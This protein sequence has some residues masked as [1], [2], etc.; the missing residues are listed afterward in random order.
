MGVNFPATCSLQNHEISYVR[1][2]FFCCFL[3]KGTNDFAARDHAIKNVRTRGYILMSSNTIGPTSW[4]QRR[5]IERLECCAPVPHTWTLRR[6][7]RNCCTK[8][9]FL[10]ITASIQWETRQTL[11]QVTHV[12][13]PTAWPVCLIGFTGA[14]V[15][16]NADPPSQQFP[17]NSSHM[18]FVELALKGVLCTCLGSKGALNTRAL[19]RM[20]IFLW[21]PRPGWYGYAHAL[22]TGQVVGWYTAHVCNLLLRLSQWES[23]L[24]KK[25]YFQLE[26]AHLV[27]KVL[28]WSVVHFLQVV[29]MGDNINKANK[30]KSKVIDP[31]FLAQIVLKDALK[32]ICNS[33]M[34]WLLH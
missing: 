19:I 32:K 6:L 29:T 4:H 33:V 14:Q 13:Q 23:I 25:T 11:K 21:L 28:N 18:Y 31:Q 7:R 10:H 34:Y 2:A 1:L 30:W 20:N 15:D 12:N 3:R 26:L 5:P 16:I 8:Q 24:N 27:G 17:A 9:V 22:G